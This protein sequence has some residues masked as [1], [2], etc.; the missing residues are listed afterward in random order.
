VIKPSP[1]ERAVP[2]VGQLLDQFE[3]RHRGTLPDRLDCGCEWRVLVAKLLFD[4]WAHGY[5]EGFANQDGL[6]ET[7][8]ERTT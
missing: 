3:E 1:S 6:T 7:G 5:A 4:A 8:I 2:I